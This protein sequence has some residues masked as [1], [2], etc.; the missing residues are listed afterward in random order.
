LLPTPKLTLRQDKKRETIPGLPAVSKDHC[1]ALP[2][3]LPIPCKSGFGAEIWELRINGVFAT[4]PADDPRNLGLGG[5][6]GGQQVNG[7]FKGPYDPRSTLREVARD[8]TPDK[9][10]CSGNKHAASRP[11]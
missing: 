6:G 8:S 7:G 4:Q 2:T 5:G 1:R 9:T 11:L 3:L 10:R